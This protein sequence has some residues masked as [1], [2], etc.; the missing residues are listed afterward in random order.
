MR[1][2]AAGPR[3]GLGARARARREEAH[4]ARIVAL[5]KCVVGLNE[6]LIKPGRRFLHE[7]VLLKSCRR[8]LKPRAFFL[9]SDL[10]FYASLNPA[11]PGAPQT[12]TVHRKL[13]LEVVRAEPQ[14]DSAVSQHAFAVLSLN[15]SFVVQASTAK[16]RD[17]WVAR[18]NDAADDYRKRRSTFGNADDAKAYLRSSITAG[19][20]RAP[21][22]GSRAVATA[23]ACTA[24]AASF[25]RGRSDSHYGIPGFM[26]PVW[27]PNDAAPACMVCRAE[28]TMLRR[29][30]HCR[31][32]GIVVCG[33]C[34]PKRYACGDGSRVRR[35]PPPCRSPVSCTP[36]LPLP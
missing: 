30:H 21:D 9:F 6:P 11:T 22:A 32:C 28:F 16:E 19:A 26:A 8:T 24:S 14:P 27:V 15:K 25:L 29:R 13:P 18:I 3:W 17:L 36:P 10:L 1:A 12:Y 5:Q 2:A 35:C 20:P 31:L 23:N 33:E 34:G 4:V 7:G